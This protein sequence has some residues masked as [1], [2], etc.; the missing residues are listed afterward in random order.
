[1]S[2]V[3]LIDDKGTQLGVIPLEEARAEAKT[4]SL[5]LVEVAPEARPI[6]CRLMD[7]G[8]EKYEREKKAKQARRKEHTISLKE[9]KFRPNIDEHDFETK[10]RRVRQFIE[11]GHHAKVS[12]MF[13]MR[14]LRRPENGFN[15]LKRVSEL[16]QDIARV[17]EPPNR[18]S[19]RVA[20]TILAPSKPKSA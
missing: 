19:H 10:T 20:T 2:P 6:V 7:W 13:R 4:R 1:M 15:I 12:V 5:D 18:A 16:L 9:V 8:R 11:K 3:L 14:E 17:E